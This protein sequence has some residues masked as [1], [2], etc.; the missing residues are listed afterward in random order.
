MKMRRQERAAAALRPEQGPGRSDRPRGQ[1]SRPVKSLQAAYEAWAKDLPQPLWMN[2]RSEEVKATLVF[3]AR[4]HS[5]LGHAVLAAERRSR[6]SSLCSPM[7][8]GTAISAVRAFMHHA[9]NID[10]LASDGTRFQQFY[11]T[12]VTCCPQPHGLHDEPLASEF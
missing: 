9:P 5:L 6:T 1:A 3:P 10:R 4:I 2:T 12:G 11:V 8:W 7:I